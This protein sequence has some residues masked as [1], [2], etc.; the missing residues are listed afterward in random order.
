ME[1]IDLAI[2]NRSKQLVPF[3]LIVLTDL[4]SLATWQNHFERFCHSEDMED[5]DLAIEQELEAVASAPLGSAIRPRFINN[6]GKSSV[7]FS[8]VWKGEGY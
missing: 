8:A 2:K 6:L 3:Q 7:S 1:D 4:D 5:I